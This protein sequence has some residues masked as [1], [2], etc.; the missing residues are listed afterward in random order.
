M[1]K[2]MLFLLFT[3][4]FSFS[5]SR[6]E[7]KAME[8]QRKADELVLDRINLHF[9]NLSA[10]NPGD[11]KAND[12]TSQRHKTYIVSQFELIGLQA[13]GNNGYIQQFV[14]DEGKKI[15]ATT[16]FTLNNTPLQL[17]KDFI[18]LVYSANQSIAGYPA[19][20]LRER[21]EPWFADIKDWLQ[22][23]NDPE[24]DIN[25]AIK[26]EVQRAADKGAT[27]LILFNSGSQ[28]DKVIFN[29]LDSSQPVSIPVIYLTPEA[30]KKYCSD[31]S[32]LIDIDLAVS[33]KETYHTAEN[34]IGF[35]DNGATNTVIIGAHYSNAT[36]MT[37]G[38]SVG[39]NTGHDNASG[40][41][42]LIE[43]ARMLKNEGTKKNNFLFIAFAAEAQDFLGSQYWLEH[44]TGKST[45]N[46]M[47]NMDM[48][49]GYLTARQLSVA[50]YKTSPQW[51]KLLTSIRQKELAINV[52]SVM[53]RQGDH[54]NFV[55]REIPVLFFYAGSTSDNQ[56]AGSADNSIQYEGELLIV[57]YIHHLLVAAD[58]AGKLVF[59][60]PAE[61]LNNPATVRFSVS[62]GII[63][64]NTYDGKGFRIGGVS[65][66]RLAEKIGLKPGDILLQLGNYKIEEM[67]SYMQ[68]LSM[69][70]KGDSATLKVL[71]N[72][73]EKLFAFEF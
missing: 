9:E 56:P 6:K 8:A 37:S 42:A 33:I 39:N 35:L 51:P 48:T 27:G 53:P 23:Q 59:S 57:K 38:Q 16:H 11:T 25:V 44:E 4:I 54:M 46:Y 73:D 69:F 67:N 68:A 72:D 60:K 52:D 55:N 58:D 32:A 71:R 22:K 47:I 40:T 34:L 14:I 50:G 29:N 61:P 2:L 64:D 20:D 12:G 28:A 63:P 10:N 31:R 13:G 18:P 49:S 17:G 1:N 19:I 65:P 66:K 26:K 36:K 30:F 24:F 21:G 45:L 62:L 43:L 5:Q 70:K 3:P 41:A 7:R 15:D